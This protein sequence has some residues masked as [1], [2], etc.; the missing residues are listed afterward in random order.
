MF[1]QDVSQWHSNFISYFPLYE[2]QPYWGDI[3][4]PGNKPNGTYTSTGLEY[5]APDG[6]KLHHSAKIHSIANAL[7]YTH[8]FTPGPMAN[9]ELDY[10]VDSRINRAEGMFIDNNGGR[11]P[12]DYSMVH[13]VNRLH[14]QGMLGFAAWGIPAGLRLRAGFENT[15]VLDHS[16]EFEKAGTA[17]STERTTWG[18]SSR[19]SDAWT[20]QPS[21]T[22]RPSPS[23]RTT[24]RC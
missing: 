14:L 6:A 2:K 8:R 23:S 12:F 4:E 11:I 10:D 24:R 17:Y 16:F 21:G 3:D 1:P 18:W 9:L 5:V 7:A 15:L 22:T 19:P 20:R 13:A